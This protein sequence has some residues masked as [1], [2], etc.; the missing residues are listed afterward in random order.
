M[1]VRLGTC[2]ERV[3]SSQMLDPTLNTSPKMVFYITQSRRH[4]NGYKP[5]VN[6]L[7]RTESWDIASMLRLG[8]WDPMLGCEL[9]VANSLF[10]YCL[11]DM[12]TYMTSLYGG[13]AWDLC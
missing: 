8:T 11:D 5:H 2:V 4:F 9:S 10:H 7:L 3:A 6:G 12:N 13:E 1:K